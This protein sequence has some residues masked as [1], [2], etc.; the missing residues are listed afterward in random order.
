MAEPKKEYPVCAE[1]GSMA[2]VRDAWAEWDHDAQDWCLQ[3]V[4][5]N[6]VCEDCDGETH[7]EWKVGNPDEEEADEEA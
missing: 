5:D 1:C 3:A 7:L 6:A 2:V 4:F